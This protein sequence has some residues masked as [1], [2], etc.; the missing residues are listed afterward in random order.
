MLVT[1]GN[2]IFNRIIRMVVEGQFLCSLGRKSASM[3]RCISRII[4]KDIRNNIE[5][6]MITN[7]SGL[8]WLNQQGPNKYSEMYG[9]INNLEAM[10]L[11][12]ISEYSLS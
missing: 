9:E 8:R 5:Q 4:L 6:I 7:H 1:Q 3:L 11:D 2:V 10:F 12:D